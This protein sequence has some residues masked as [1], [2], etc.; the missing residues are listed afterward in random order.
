MIERRTTSGQTIVAGDVRVTTQSR[1]VSVRLPLGAFVW[2]RPTAVVI[3]RAGVVER[4]RIVDVTRI[5]QGA[6]GACMVAAFVAGWRAARSR[7]GE[8]M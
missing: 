7:R 5:A 8:P 1:V 6:L 4:R 3:E 2:H